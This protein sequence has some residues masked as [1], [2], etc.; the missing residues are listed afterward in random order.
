MNFTPDQLAKRWDCTSNAIRDMCKRKELDH[1]RVGKL[2][3]I[4]VRV[5]EEKERCGTDSSNIE[6]NSLSHG[7]KMVQRAD[8]RL[9]RMTG[10]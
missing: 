7:Q 1:F 9:A 3:R 8:I 6:E 10:N 4:P 5:V 2:Y